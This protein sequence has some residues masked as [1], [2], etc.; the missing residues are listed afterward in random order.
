MKE[1]EEEEEEVGNGSG[2]GHAG[3]GAAA[4]AGGGGGGKLRVRVEV[5]LT[6][7]CHCP[8]QIISSAARY[9]LTPPPP[10]T[11][12]R[13]RGPQWKSRMCIRECMRRPNWCWCR[14]FVLCIRVDT[15]IPIPYHYYE[16]MVVRCTFSRSTHSP[17]A[18]VL[19]YTS[20][21]YFATAFPSSPPSSSSLSHFDGCDGG[22]GGATI[23]R[24]PLA[25]P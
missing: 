17:R 16:G 12:L 5:T 18:A 11:F 3:D 22:V 10:Q 19:L 9:T 24:R 2:G 21:R 20:R 7:V 8:R 4:V 23:Y 14:L 15:Y 25:T 1:E 6:G 13:T